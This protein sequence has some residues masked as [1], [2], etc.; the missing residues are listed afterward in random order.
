[1]IISR[2][3]TDEL[4]R[5]HSAMSVNPEHQSGSGGCGAGHEYGMTWCRVRS[6]VSPQQAHSAPGGMGTRLNPALAHRPFP[7]RAPLARCHSRSC[8][9]QRVPAVG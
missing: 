1:M 7:R 6:E 5:R 8:S 2:S 9:G 3:A 4:H